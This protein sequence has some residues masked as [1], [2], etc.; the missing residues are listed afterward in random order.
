MIIT[1]PCGTDF[2]IGRYRNMQPRKTAVS[3]QPV[4]ARLFFMLGTTI[5]I[6]MP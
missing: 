5:A 2:N 6:N 1:N 3:T 4:V